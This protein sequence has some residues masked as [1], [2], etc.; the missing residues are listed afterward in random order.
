M[1]MMIVNF[2]LIVIMII[3]MTM[4][5]MNHV[6]RTTNSSTSTC[7]QL[8]NN[9]LETRNCYSH[10]CSSLRH[11]PWAALRLVSLTQPLRETAIKKG[12]RCQFHPDFD[13]S[14]FPSLSLHLT[15]PRL[16]PDPERGPVTCGL[17]CG[18]WTMCCSK[19]SR[20]FKG[21]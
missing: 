6:L 8:P 21:P 1:I 19:T 10:F 4:M 3:T 9:A 7:E 14:S 16:D 11:S 17:P 2:V 18:P 12:T 5:I 13:S 20:V 15:R